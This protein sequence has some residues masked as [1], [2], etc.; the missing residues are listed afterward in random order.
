MSLALGLGLALLLPPQGGARPAQ[1]PDLYARVLLRGLDRAQAKVL[2]GLTF[3]VDH[4]RWEDPWVVTTA[5]YQVR[6]TGSYLQAHEVARDLEFL[7]GEFVKV[8]GEGRAPSGPRPVFILPT[9]GDYNRFG[10]DHG[11]EHSS[12]LGSFYSDQHPE[13]PVVTYQNGNSTWLGMWITHSAVHQF[14]EQGFGPQRELWVSEGLASY[15]ALYWDWRYGARELER[16][17][18]GPTY[19]SLEKLVRDPIQ[20]YSRHP[21]DRFIELGMLFNFLLNHCEATKNGATGDPTTGP[22]QEFLRAAVRGQSVTDTEFFQTLEEAS[23]LLEQDFRE[24]E[25]AQ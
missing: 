15:F 1:A 25:F 20:A 6:T 3:E 17:E 11:A 2:A 14:L 13:Q 23:A 12:L 22:F 24:F 9:I 8:L 4:S 7:R 18:K 21:D 19:V 10:N 5:H 16:I